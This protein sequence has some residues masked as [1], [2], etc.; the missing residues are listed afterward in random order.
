[1]R[2]HDER[3]APWHHALAEAWLVQW[4]EAQLLRSFLR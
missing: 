4:V 1:V 3:R 2:L